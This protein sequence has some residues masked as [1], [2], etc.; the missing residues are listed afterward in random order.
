ML[1]AFVRIDL[2]DRSP[3]FQRVALEPGVPLLD[4][5]QTNA[6]LLRVWLGRFIAE[7][8][9]V[10]SQTLQ[11]YLNDDQGRR[12]IANEVRLARAED[13]DG[14]LKH[15]MQALR[16]KLNDIQPRG[17]T[18][19]AVV[20]LLRERFEKLQKSSSDGAFFC[21]RDDQRKWRLVWCWGYQRSDSKF[22]Q[23]FLCLKPGCNRLYLFR[24]QEDPKCTKCG[25]PLPKFRFPWKRV[26]MAAVVLLVVAALGGWQYWNTL[27]RSSIDGHVVWRG[28]NIPVA[29]ARIRIESMNVETS[30]DEQ[31]R[32]HLERLPARSIDVT[33]TADGFPVH[34]VKQVLEQSKQTTMPVELTAVGILVGRVID[35]DSRQ[36][37]PGVTLKM[38]GTQET[39]QTDDNGLFRY[40]ACRLGPTK[41]EIAAK[42]YPT[43]T[44]DA[45]VTDSADTD[46]VH[47]ISGDAVL[48]GRVVSADQEQPL[49]DI[50][51]RLDES[52][53]TAKTD[54]DGWYA[55]QRAPHG[56][57]EIVVEQEGFAT[58]RIEKE[59]VAGQERQASFK[60]AGA[61]KVSGRVMRAIDMSPMKRVDVKVAGTRLGSRTDDDG[62]FRLLGIVAGKTTIEVAAPGFKKEILAKVLSNSEETILEFHLE[63]DAALTGLVTDEV[64]KQPV[65]NVEVRLEGTP[66]QAKSDAEGRYRLD[67]VP[68][69]SAKL[70]VQSAGYHAK[71]IEIRPAA[72]EVT[73]VPVALTGNAALSGTVTERWSEAPVKSTITIAGTKLSL[74]T[75]NEG[76]FE[77]K[78]L[79]SGVKH[80]LR[81]DAEGLVS[82]VEEVVLKQ[83]STVPIKVILSG[84]AR[85]MGRVVSV[86][87]EAPIA[88]ASIAL[89]DTKHQ[90]KANSKGEFV[91]DQLRTGRTVIDVSADGFEKQRL[92]QEASV[93]SKPMLILLGGSASVTGEIM[94]AATGLPIADVEIQIADTALKSRTTKQ[95]TYELKGAFA[96]PVKL[97]ASADG[98]PS[99]SESVEL[100]AE[101]ESKVDLTLTGTAAVSGEV[102]DDLDKPVQSAVV[103][104]EDTGHQVKTGSSG[105][106]QLT[107]LRAGTA[108]F[109]VKAPMFARKSASAELKSGEV[110]SLGRLKLVSSLAL[111]G[112][113]TN[114][115]TAA[116]VANAKVTIASLQMTT[117]TDSEG[118]FQFDGLPAKL[119]NVNIEATDYVA[120]VFAVNPV[121]EE[122]KE[123]FYLCPIPQPNE[124]LI[125]LNWRGNERGLN[126]HFYREA[127]SKAEAHVYSGQPQAD[128]L[129]LATTGQNVQRPQTVRIHPLQP[130]RYEMV[131]AVAP[132]EGASNDP[133]QSLK[134]L[135][136]SEATVKVY[137]NGQSVPA[138][139]RVGR[140]KNATVW[141]PFGLEILPS[142]KIVDHVYKAEHYKT[143]LPSEIR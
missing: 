38:D 36:P 46:A 117:S 84:V 89:A 105:E 138:V 21:F 135:S 87:D 16:G 104:L 126:A 19:Q 101:K 14:K 110:K 27:P 108:R 29:N 12:I 127:N 47:E 90:V 15:E 93:E 52:G 120:E 1:S 5:G 24:G 78:G 18:E 106:F 91:L 97:T 33:I 98:Y 140:N 49:R 50:S 141:Q 82:H 121:I 109:S 20:N 112:E 17:R 92:V 95:G 9:W 99:R 25:T 73:S 63:G 134:Y 143:T 96:G 59:L 10:D 67:A 39:I 69:L 111:R 23:P 116:P 8:E 26:G 132:D 7:P 75:D 115:L 83:G 11:F 139:Y 43:V 118:R 136:L 81:I 124:V 66:F 122:Q 13:L 64:T 131:V 137:R 30:T 142:G 71:A 58:E 65:S 129:S 62:H 70:N 28:F 44:R 102:Y 100:V 61:A 68:S 114:S 51:V 55:F 56:P 22:A 60:L 57:Q 48:V 45:V 113:V 74:S 76:T 31:G 6:R 72:R 41:I 2:P 53:Q 54:A 85:Q 88:G 94:D 42:G 80:E 40:E 79:R 130:G 133:T 119:H 86:I 32:F 35:A 125:V 128:N 34:T 3:D 4:R 107:Q 103:A 123:Q 77:I 37:L